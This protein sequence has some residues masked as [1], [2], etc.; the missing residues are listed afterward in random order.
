MHLLIPAADG[1]V[2][3]QAELG[4]VVVH[5]SET[6]QQRMLV[7]PGEIADLVATHAEWLRGQAR[8]S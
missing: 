6:P 7:E 8:A 2:H 3:L 1:A 4:R 5:A